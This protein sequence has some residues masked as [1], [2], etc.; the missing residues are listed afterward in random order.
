ME[1]IEDEP[2]KFLKTAIKIRENKPDGSM[3]VWDIL[4]F[5]RFF[6]KHITK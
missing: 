6:E 4:A 5:D 1:Q 2:R 3:K